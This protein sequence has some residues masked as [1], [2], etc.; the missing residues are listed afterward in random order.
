ML[1]KPRTKKRRST[2][3]SDDEESVGS[4]SSDVDMADVQEPSPPPSDDEEEPGDEKLGRG[5]RSRAKV[6][7]YVLS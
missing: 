7:G 3:D 5:A 4:K 6:G 1:R 2:N